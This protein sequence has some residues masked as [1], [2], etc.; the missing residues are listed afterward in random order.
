[1]MTISKKLLCAVALGLGLNTSLSTFAYDAKKLQ[2]EVQLISE[3]IK[4]KELSTGGF[5]CN[6]NL[7]RLNSELS[8]LVNNKTLASENIVGFK[9]AQQVSEFINNRISFI[10]QHNEIVDKNSTLCIWLK[11]TI[12]NSY[13]YWASNDDILKIANIIETNSSSVEEELYA[14]RNIIDKRNN[15]IAAIA[16]ICMFIAYS[17]LVFSAYSR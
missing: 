12:E 4:D 9:E 15:T 7:K 3:F 1:M 5:Y 11:K 6:E 17:K 10:E 2:K 13:V 8:E 16:S 14:I